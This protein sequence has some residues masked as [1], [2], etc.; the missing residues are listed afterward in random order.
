MR[1]KEELTN[2]INEKTNR[3]DNL[4]EED[5]INESIK[6]NQSK[7]EEYENKIS[8]GY[9][10]EIENIKAQNEKVVSDTI[11]SYENEYARNAVQKV[12]NEKMIAEKNANLGISN[13]GLN[14]TQLTAAQLSYANQKGKLDVAKESELKDLT[15]NLDNNIIMLNQQKDNEIMQNSKYWDEIST[16]EGIRNF[17]YEK[18]DLANDIALDKQELLELETMEENQKLYEIY[19][20]STTTSTVDNNS[21]STTN[22]A[23][24]TTTVNSTSN[25]ATGNSSQSK[26][27]YVIN[28]SGGLLSRDYYGTLKDNNVDTIYN[29]SGDKIANV[30]YVDNNS[31]QKTTLAYGI[32][33]YT[34]DNNV[35]G[36]SDAAKAV[37][38]Y[39]AYS[40]GYQPKGVVKN[41]TDYGKIVGAVDKTDPNQTYGI[42]FN[43]HKTTENGTHYWIWDAT[44]NNYMEV[45]PTGEGSN[46]KWVLKG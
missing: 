4:S 28:T 5:F 35:K 41:G 8:A 22:T 12:I 30:T 39:N 31:G 24:T 40:N 37:Y 2:E 1:T 20:N 19:G 34:G 45:I 46:K 27:S 16:E 23:V 44:Q 6:K 36:G 9:D 18:S 3:Y 14:K 15:L 17:S 43:I 25:T 29:Y 10:Q 11:T 21:D 26:K 7:K 33:P 42:A 13:S 38:K 32:N